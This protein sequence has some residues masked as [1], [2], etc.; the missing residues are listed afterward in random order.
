MAQASRRTDVQAN[1]KLP[2]FLVPQPGREYFD[3][4]DWTFVTTG[5]RALRSDMRAIL[6]S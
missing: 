6:G 5:E 1:Q 2:A 3:L 4:N